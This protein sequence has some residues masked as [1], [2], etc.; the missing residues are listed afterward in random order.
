MEHVISFFKKAGYT[1]MDFSSTAD[2]VAFYW[3]KMDN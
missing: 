2:K 1:V 3:D